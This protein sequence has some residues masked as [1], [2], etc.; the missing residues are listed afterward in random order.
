M[1]P[2]KKEKQLS[3]QEVV[4]ANRRAYIEGGFPEALFLDHLG[5]DLAKDGSISAWPSADNVPMQGGEVKAI[6][7]YKL[8]KIVTAARLRTSF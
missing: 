8:E 7:I 5:I 2:R 1:G 3:D 4:A 6:A